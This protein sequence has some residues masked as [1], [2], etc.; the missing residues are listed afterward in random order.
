MAKDRAAKSA[1]REDLAGRFNKATASVI[2]EY[3]GVTALEMAELRV[4]LRKVNTEFRV[5]KNRV[6]KKAIE[7]EAQNSSALAT[8][9][10][11][12]IGIAY[13][14]GDVA[15]GTKAILAFEKTHEKF[16]VTAG[17]MEGQVLGVKELKA[18]SD[19]PSK[20]VLLAKIIGSLVAPHRGLLTV[21]NGV[22]TNL[23]RVLN[24]I[25][26]TKS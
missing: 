18:L 11:G 3:R 1:L 19:L 15:A 5:I 7:Q 20:E 26:D 21:L 9:L 2:A 17:V 12:P 25:K 4:E 16:K 22:G 23:V 8:K 14:Y 6:A 10:V 13:M 24:A